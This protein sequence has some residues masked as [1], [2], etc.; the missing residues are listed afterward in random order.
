MRVFDFDN[1]IYNGESVLDFYLYSIRYYPGALKYLFVVLWHFFRYKLSKTTM[2]ELEQGI[3]AYAIDYVRSF[4]NQDAIVS[5][6]WDKRMRKIKA[7]YT[8]QPD[9]VILTASFNVIIDEACRRLGVSHCICS[10][11]NRETM[12]LEYLNFS[13]NKREIFLRTFGSQ[14]VVEEFYTDSLFDQPMIDLAEKAYLVKGNKIRRV[15]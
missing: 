3:K 13:R 11:V 14:A 9:D 12:E 7:W 2:E 6:F 8:P 4:Q 1:T 5:A 10:V 15:K